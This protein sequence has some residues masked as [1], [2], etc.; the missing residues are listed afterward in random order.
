MC[1]KQTSVSSQLHRIWDYIVGCW[2]ADVW[3]T[4]YQ[5]TTQACTRE[6]GVEVQ[7]THKIK[8]VLGQ[9]V[10]QLNVDQ[11]PSSAHLSEKGSQLYIFEDN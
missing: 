8:Q 10:G 9:I 1:K 5:K 11:V 4:E 6:T 3:F 7:S 2:F